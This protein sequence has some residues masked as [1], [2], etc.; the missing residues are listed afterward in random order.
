MQDLQARLQHL[1]QILAQAYMRARLLWQHVVAS[2]PAWTASLKYDVEYV[3]EY[4]IGVLPAWLAT[5]RAALRAAY[6]D[7]R[8]T[9]AMQQLASSVSTAAKDVSV[10]IRRLQQAVADTNQLA[11]N[12]W[13]SK[14]LCS[15]VD[16]PQRNCSNSCVRCAQCLASLQCASAGLLLSW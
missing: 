10:N 6:D 2:W 16:T 13:V 11:S 8:A 7:V 1:S 5:V 15:E 12:R 4:A 3:V 14:G 9:A